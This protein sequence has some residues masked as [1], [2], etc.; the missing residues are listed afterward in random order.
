MAGTDDR[1]VRRDGIV[2]AEHALDLGL[3]CVFGDP[4][5]A[6]LHRNDVRLDTDVGCALHEP[7]LVAGLEQPQFV[8]QVPQFEEFVR[9]LRT[10]PHHGAH[11]IQPADE[12]EV[13][14][15]I[16]TEVVVNART[17]FEQAGQDLI[18]IIDGIGVIHAERLDRSFR[19]AAGTIP[20]FAIRVTLAT[21]QDRFAVRAARNQH[22]HRVGLGKTSEV[23]QVGIL[24]VRVMGIAAAD[25]FRRRRK[26]QDGV[27]AGHSHQL[28]A[29]PRVG[30]GRNGNG[31]AHG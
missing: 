18:E 22:Q 31:F 30:R 1:A 25:A 15:G 5:A 20:A 14:V 6:G 12:L 9:R 24:P 16:V 29:A 8:E 3:Q 26:N 27:V 7:D 13:E 4:C 2:H 10:H 17:P 19:A 23:Q 11:A 21:E 28:L